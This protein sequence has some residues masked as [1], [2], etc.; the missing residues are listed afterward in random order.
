MNICT[1][2]PGPE[3]QH[4]GHCGYGPEDY[5]AEV[6]GMALADM[7]RHL[8]DAAPVIRGAADEFR[9]FAESVIETCAA[10]L[11]GITPGDWARAGE[12]LAALD[13]DCCDCPT[14]L[15]TMRCGAG[16]HVRVIHNRERNTR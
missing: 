9:K 12:L 1:C 3:G 5:A 2:D 10:P 13:I 8:A 7:Q 6:V 15:H 16:G 11:L 4:A 14:P